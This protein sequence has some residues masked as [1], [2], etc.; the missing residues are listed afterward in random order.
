MN[1]RDDLDSIYGGSM[2]TALGLNCKGLLL[3]CVCAAGPT[4]TAQL[5][6]NRYGGDACE[7]CV[8]NPVEGSTTTDGRWSPSLA[9]TLRSV[10][11]P[12]AHP[13][14]EEPSRYYDVWYRPSA[15]GRSA[16][17][18]FRPEPFTPRGYGNL[19]AAPAAPYRI[20]YHRY[21]L[22][23][24]YSP[25]GPSYYRRSKDRPA[26]PGLRV[27]RTHRATAPSHR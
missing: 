11:G 13:R 2:R 3:L 23:S 15:F 25:Y 7:S 20:D 12:E 21:V 8:T 6:Q 10:P 24:P 19:F 14:Y 17:E 4:A 18:R 22:E 5:R 27:H 16:R 26:H 9:R 1:L